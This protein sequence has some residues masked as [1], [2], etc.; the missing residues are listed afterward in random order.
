LNDIFLEQW[1]GQGR[2]KALR[3]SSPDLNYLDLNI[4]GCLKST[5]C[6]TEGTD[7]QD[8]QKRT[9]NGF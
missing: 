8:L 7:V 6:A 4:C 5:L 1:I 9:W 2:P 3:V